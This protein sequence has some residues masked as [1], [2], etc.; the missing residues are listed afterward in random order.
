MSYNMSKLGDPE[1]DTKGQGSND[2]V[3]EKRLVLG[4]L[5]S[6]ILDLE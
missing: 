4:Y 5:G 6:S 2:R 1:T 3:K